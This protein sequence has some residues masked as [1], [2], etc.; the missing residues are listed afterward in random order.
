MLEKTEL[1]CPIC[2][3]PTY[4]CYGHPRKD[5]LC[6]KHGKQATEGIIKQCPDCGK[7]H[8]A[9]EECQCKKKIEQENQ[10]NTNELTCIICNKPSYG[11]HFCLDCYRKYK[12][13]TIILQV[14]K[15][16]KSKIMNDYYEGKYTC[17]DGHIVKSL[18][19][20]C[21]DDYLYDENINHAYEYTLPIDNDANHNLHPD[22]YI[23]EYNG[24]K[25]IYIEHWGYDE[26]NIEYT[27][28]KEY[29]MPIYERLCKEEGITLIY[30]TIKDIEDI[31]GAM[32]RKLKFFKPKQTNE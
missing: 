14:D 8:N 28:K 15:C 32:K 4:L 29:K 11:K 12:N 20:R 27:K 23:P 22:F 3:E 24:T 26:T 7:W 16:I 13:K 2:G 10:N 5:L 25:D 17:K 9:N 18:A 1:K 21:I 6:A 31:Y 19:E 30:T